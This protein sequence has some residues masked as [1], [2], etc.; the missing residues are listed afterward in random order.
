M[1]QSEFSRTDRGTQ[2]SG[3]AGDQAPG[4][5]A[6]ERDRPR[7]IS[8]GA[9]RLVATLL[10]IVYLVTTFVV[11]LPTVAE[12][13]PGDLVQI[14]Y[15]PLEETQVRETL[16]SLDT[17]TNNVIRSV[18]SISIGFDNTII[19]FDHHEDGFEANVS[20]PIQATS[21]VWGDG[22]LTNGVAPGHPSDLLRAGDTIALENDVPLPRT[23]AI[24]YDG[25]DKIGVTG[26][27]AM[28]KAIWATTPGVVLAGASEI[29][30]TSEYG[31][32]FTS[33]IG[34][35]VNA[36]QMF[37]Y[38]ALFIMAENNGTTVNIDI[39]GNGSTD[40]TTVLNAGG[41]YLVDGGVMAGA[42]VSAS[43]PVQ[44]HAFAGDIDASGGY[45]SRLITLRP[46]AAWSSSYYSPVGSVNGQST[47]Y[48]IYNPNT[49]NVTINY[50][51]QSGSGSFSAAARSVT[52]FLAPLNTGVHLYSSGASFFA[53]V[54]V[55]AEPT[56]N[57]AYDWGFALTPESKLGRT[58]IVGWGPGSSDLSINVSPLWV[59]ANTATTL[60]V[61]YDGDP[62]TGPNVDPDGGR[63]NVA[64]PA[65]AL[66]SV[67]ILDPTDNDQTGM[68]VY[69][70]NGA[71]IAAAYG[72]DP[73]T[74]PAGAPALDLGTTVLAV[75]GFRTSKSGAVGTDVNGNGL[76]DP[77]DSIL[78]T[79]S[80]LNDSTKPLGGVTVI[81]TVPT[82][83]SY[84]PGSSTVGGIPIADDGTGTAFPFDDGGYLVG[85]VGSLGTVNVTFEVVVNPSIPVQVTSVTNLALVA[86]E[87]GALQTEAITEVFRPGVR[88]DK[89]SDVTGYVVP[90][91][92]IT[93]TVDVFNSGTSVATGVDVID[94]VPAGTSYVPDSATVA[95][96]VAQTY[97]DRFDVVSFANDDGTM[98]WSNTWQETD[99]GGSGPSAG[100]VRVQAD[101]P[102]TALM[103]SST[104]SQVTRQ[105]DLSAYA[106]ANLSFDYRR[107]GFDTTSDFVTLDVSPDGGSTWI[108][109][110]RFEGP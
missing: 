49:S 66:Q 39:D 80:V 73:T 92:T 33:P 78:Y 54:M 65:A 31:T 89:T 72:Q 67:K 32:M 18:T 44:V 85:S 69:T 93:Y 17:S 1:E 38:V 26:L 64:I 75:E 82:Y 70:V 56:S 90:G 77:G 43:G 29:L 48:Y 12:A 97:L 105:A 35:N 22:N 110:D 13:A 74:A 109:L 84:V 81:D 11:A 60:Y 95:Y 46:D 87:R 62:S 47:F 34:Q 36:N 100:W 10:S 24:L 21:Q 41:S 94:Q 96:P 52:Q 71:L 106:I 76:V 83:T 98:T 59:T 45:E 2:A 61:D 30:P 55:G 88:I 16:F 27:V 7:R 63:Y 101:G 99:A 19:Y 68:R 91:Q 53:S 102:E 86:T 20:A 5:P 57:S 3:V 6:P 4:R 15:V 8:W 25:G 9:R 104:N 58:V 37:E 40:V 107:A 50:A 51:T 23:G 28:T 14:Y 108:E 79:I 103:L 42:T